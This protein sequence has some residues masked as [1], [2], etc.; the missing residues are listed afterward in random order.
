MQDIATE[1]TDYSKKS[2]EEGAQA[3][4]KL[5]GAKSL[6]Q[7]LEVRTSFAKK[8]Y[9]GCMAQFSKLNEIYVDL[10]EA[11]RKPVETAIANKE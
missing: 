4:E 11:A 9:D 10:S 7:A 6:E 5:V 1:V 8:A 2:F 3:F